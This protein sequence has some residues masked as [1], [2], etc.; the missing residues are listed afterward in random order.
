MLDNSELQLDFSRELAAIVVPE[1]APFFDE[2]VTSSPA[3]VLR[4]DHDLG[5]GGQEA[6]IGAM[7]LFLMDVGK[8]VLAVLWQQAQKSVSDLVSSA[9]KEAQSQLNEAIGA[10]INK[11]FAGPSPVNLPPDVLRDLLETVRKDAANKGVGEPELTL[12]TQTLTNV[13]A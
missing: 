10:W 3:K 13:L 7:S 2:L 6:L 1:E 4:K 12:L 9:A 8:T 11:R 5:F